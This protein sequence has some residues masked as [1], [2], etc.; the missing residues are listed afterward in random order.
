MAAG[1]TESYLGTTLFT[2]FLLHAF[3]DEDP[4]TIKA[5]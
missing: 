5:F 2:S 1:I 3:L 4:Q